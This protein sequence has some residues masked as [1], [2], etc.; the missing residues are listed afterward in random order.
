M[1]K[2]TK[3]ILKE[4]IKKKLSIKLEEE[5]ILFY[6]YCIDRQLRP[7]EAYEVIELKMRE[8][9]EPYIFDMT[10]LDKLIV[11]YKVYSYTW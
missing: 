5:I 7:V 3:K 1:K 6:K 2:K 9:L 4:K 8:T 10:V 11:K